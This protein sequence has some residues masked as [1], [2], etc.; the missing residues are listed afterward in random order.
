MNRN[1]RK[2]LVVLVAAVLVLAACGQKQGV[3]LSAGGGSGGDGSG[4]SDDGEGTGADGTGDDGSGTGADG[5][6]T[7]GSGGSG[8]GGTNG[9]G[10]TGTA[11]GTST[12]TGTRAG[13]RAGTPV[14]GAPDRTG[15]DDANKVI[16]IGVHAPVT[17]AAPIEQK[18][19]DKGKDVYWQWLAKNGGLY[20]GYRVEIKFYDD[21]FEPVEARRRCSQL[22][23]QDKVFLLIGAAGADQITA[24]A[25][26]ANSKNV[27]Y[28]S[29]GVNTEGLDG[30]R[31]YFAVSETYAQQMPQLAQMVKSQIGVKKLGLAVLDSKSFADA[32]AAAR[33]AFTAA[34]FQIVADKNVPKDTN[35][36]GGKAI[37]GDLQD[38][39]AEIVLALV[40]PTI[41]LYIANGAQSEA[42]FPEYV[43]PGVTNG[44]NTVATAGCPAIG[45][46]KFFSPFPQLDAI[47]SMDPAYRPAY[48]EFI[49]NKDSSQRPDDIGIALWGLNKSLHQMFKAIPDV[50]QLSRQSFISTLTS[51]KTFSTGVYPSVTFSPTDH[52]GADTVHLLEADCQAAPAQFKTKAKFAKSF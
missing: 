13:T 25:N 9:G 18:T 27:P 47:D 36:P 24:C 2:W 51:G 48:Q 16:K 19:F 34:G 22:V 52:F 1:A 23:E 7:D 32:R 10:S 46:A 6:G 12:R 33:K 3:S 42:Y 29:A 39:G 37:A 49:T 31:T 43:G 11:G 17:G 41:F 5:T 44:L 40:S 14:P 35:A 26:Y 21:K 50:K 45:K 28:L 38:A 4:F 20:G 15:I 30:L 8:S